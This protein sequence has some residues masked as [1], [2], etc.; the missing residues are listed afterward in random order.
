[1][2]FLDEERPIQP[3]RSLWRSP[4]RTLHLWERNS[5]SR[6]R[7]E[8]A[9]LASVGFQVDGDGSFFRQVHRINLSRLC[10]TIGAVVHQFVVRFCFP[11]L[12]TRE[13]INHVLV[14][15]EHDHGVIPAA[16]DP[17][18]ASVWPDVDAPS[19]ALSRSSVSAGHGDFPGAPPQ[20]LRGISV[21]FWRPV[22]IVIFIAVLFV[23]LRYDPAGLH[24]RSI[25]V[26]FSPVITGSP[27]RMLAAP[28][29]RTRM[30]LILSCRSRSMELLMTFSSRQA[31]PP[32][33]S[34][35]VEEVIPSVK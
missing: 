24:G 11:P 9:C 15:L 8:P 18:S 25:I 21:R 6:E 34:R 14:S 27:Q 29:S 31:H 23:R 35:A 1:M 20:S 3:T 2:L 22:R 32:K 10:Q 30:R 26:K 4:N 17:T 13:K 33:R 28:D 7:A 5:F 19:R 12:E 16:I